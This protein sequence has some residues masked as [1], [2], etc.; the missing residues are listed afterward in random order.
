MK[1]GY[2]AL[3]YKSIVRR[4]RGA[5]VLVIFVSHRMDEV[6][7]SVTHHTVSMV[8]SRSRPNR[9]SRSP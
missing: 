6:M 1:R 8:S 2:T 5:G 9:A 3:E 4:L 7:D